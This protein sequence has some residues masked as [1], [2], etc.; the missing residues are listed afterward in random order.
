MGTRPAAEDPQAILR[1]KRERL[2]IKAQATAWAL[3]YYLSMAYPVE[4]RQ[5]LAALSQLPRDLPLEGETVAAVFRRT[6]RLDGSPEADARFAERW[7]E[8]IRTLPPAYIDIALVE[9]KPPA[10]NGTNPPGYP[11]LP[12][13][14]PGLPPGSGPGSPDGGA[15]GSGPGR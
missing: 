5:F 8:F 10:S 13:G 4:F 15:P 12:P 3:Y 14:Y 9:P 1:K 6:F 11:G 7:L 2:N